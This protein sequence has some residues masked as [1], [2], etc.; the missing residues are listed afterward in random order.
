MDA[1]VSLGPDPVWLFLLLGVRFWPVFLLGAIAAAVAAFVLRGGKRLLAG[2]AA[3]FLALGPIGAAVVES[4]RRAEDAR[5][6]AEYTRTHT[7]L[8]AETTIDGIALPAGTEVTWEDA[9]RARLA[10]ASLPR[11]ADVLGVEADYVGRRGEDGW[12]VH[13][14]GPRVL[15]GW[16]CDGF[17]VS[18]GRDGRLHSCMLSRPVEWN[19]WTLPAQTGVT[20][21]PAERKLGLFFAY[22]ATVAYPGIE[23]PLPRAQEVSV[24]DDGSLDAAYFLP[25]P[26][27]LRG[28]ALKRVVEWRYDPATY[29]M[30]RDR[31]PVAV[32]TLVPVE[33]RQDPVRVVV[34]LPG[35]AVTRE[36]ARERE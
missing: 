35:G 6:Q 27:V 3:A 5:F 4:G 26:L 17:S 25:E 14:T 1:L 13:M 36:G 24:N 15:D 23:R 22:D 2:F 20:P 21:R 29:G 16:P 28:V 18:L 8:T 30:G 12:T 7:V 10:A 19:G 11:P 9:S 31:P 33:G 34:R 32:T